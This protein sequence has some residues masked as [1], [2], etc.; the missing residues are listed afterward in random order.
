MEA[1]DPPWPQILDRFG[2]N[3]VDLEPVSQFVL[4]HALLDQWL[5]NALALHDT[6]ASAPQTQ[7]DVDTLVDGFIEQH[8]QGTFGKRLDLVRRLALLS[9]DHLA[10]CEE[11]NRARNYFLHWKQGRFEVPRYRGDDVRQ[12]GVLEQCLRDVNDVVVALDRAL[13]VRRG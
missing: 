4:L 9:E 12:S 6:V 8:S 7:K 2:M 1:T 13:R 10:T 3:P 11:M 5:I